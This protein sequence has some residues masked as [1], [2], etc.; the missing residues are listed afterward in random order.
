MTIYVVVLLNISAWL[1]QSGTSYSGDYLIMVLFG[2]FLFYLF[3]DVVDVSGIS[4]T[5]Y[6]RLVCCFRDSVHSGSLK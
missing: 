5:L 2:V 3:V 6:S 4:F 1:A